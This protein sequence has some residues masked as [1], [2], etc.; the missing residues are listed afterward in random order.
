MNV[1]ESSLFASFSSVNR[2]NARDIA[3]LTFLYFI[4]LHVLRVNWHSAPLARQYAQ[5]TM[6]HGGWEDPY[7]S[8]TDLYQLLNITLAHSS[9]FVAHLKNPEASQALVHDLML[10][11]HDVKRFLQNI[12]SS[13]YSDD[14]SARLLFRF[15]REL[16]ITVT[17]YK[18]VRRICVDWNTSHIDDE[19]K[20]L[21]VT[22]LLQ[23]MR[24]R[25]LRG[26]L[27]RPLQEL[28]QRERL[29]L[30]QACDPETGRNCDVPSHPTG[31]PG[32]LGL[33]RQLA[34][35]AGLG[36]GAYYLGKALAGGFRK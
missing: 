34:V 26:D 11:S 9:N 27:I 6:S 23:A 15:E 17:N 12:A 24:N 5:R 29:E 30:K 35:G 1:T 33:L 16:R 22:R 31:E 2:Y 36:V 10:D 20:S 7:L 18:S 32:K 28:A 25:A 21:A 4:T 3:D 13:G 19:A 8:G 14:L